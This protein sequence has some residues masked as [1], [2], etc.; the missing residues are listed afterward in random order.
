MAQCYSV[1]VCIA[2]LVDEYQLHLSFGSL[3]VL[4]VYHPVPEGG[5][6]GG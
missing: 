6:G 5:G 4:S 2:G 3:S 1:V